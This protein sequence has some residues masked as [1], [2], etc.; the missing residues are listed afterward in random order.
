MGASNLSKPLFS[1]V[2]VTNCFHTDAI[3]HRA[4]PQKVGFYGYG[5]LK[6]SVMFCQVTHNRCV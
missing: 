1:Q 4:H 6:Y 2:C 5:T 3:Q